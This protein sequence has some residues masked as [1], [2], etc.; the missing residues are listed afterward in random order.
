[1]DHMLTT[2]GAYLCPASSIWPFL[3]PKHGLWYF[4]I[5]LDMALHWCGVLADT[6]CTRILQ[7]I[8]IYSRVPLR[9]APFWYV[10]FPY[11]HKVILAMPIGNQ[12]RSKRG[13]SMSKRLHNT[14][15]HYRNQCFNSSHPVQ[16][17]L[18][19]VGRGVWNDQEVPWKGNKNVCTCGL[20]ILTV[21][22]RAWRY[23]TRS[24]G[25][26]SRYLEK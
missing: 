16:S 25:W 23:I 2:C 20:T 4:E 17:G 1:M 6:K 13:F 24:S 7:T 22:R 3:A 21:Y 9:E 12:H 11:G 26:G 5:L 10:L 19:Q 15:G 14:F 18:A 8:T